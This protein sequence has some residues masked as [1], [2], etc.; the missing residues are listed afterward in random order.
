MDLKKTWVLFFSVMTAIYLFSITSQ[1]CSCKTV[2]RKTMKS[3]RI[4][5][6]KAIQG[7]EKYFLMWKVNNAKGERGFVVLY[8][9][10][11]NSCVPY[12]T[13]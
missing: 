3:K 6:D 5:L 1:V 8:S 11:L 4:S 9:Y 10:R 12:S 7:V 13:L 2:V